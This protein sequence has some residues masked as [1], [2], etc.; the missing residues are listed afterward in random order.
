MS[1]RSLH[2]RSLPAA[3]C[4]ALFAATCGTNTEEPVFPVFL[5]FSPVAPPALVSVAAV[6]TQ[7]A[8]EALRYEFDVSYYVTNSEDGFLGYNLY[9]SSSATAAEAAIL[10]IGGEPYLE[11]GIKPSFSHAGENPSTAAVDL[12]TQR[13]QNFRA[14]PAPISFKACELYFFTLTAQTR[15]SLE[16]NPSPQV[17]ACAALDPGLCP[18]GTPCNP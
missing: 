14:A 11:T 9:L 8:G 17:A 1:G 6:E 7:N 10:G 15:N 13:V 16:S 3:F 5:I 2:K 18:S 4:L 12:Q